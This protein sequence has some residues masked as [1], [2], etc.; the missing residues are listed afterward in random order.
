MAGLKALKKSAKKD[1]FMKEEMFKNFKLKLTSDDM[2]M[3]SDMYYAMYAYEL[4]GDA[5]RDNSFFELVS[6]GK[7]LEKEDLK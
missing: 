6:I 1:N 5:A 3:G 4:H 2:P 7:N